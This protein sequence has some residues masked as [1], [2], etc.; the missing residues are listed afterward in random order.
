MRNL[1]YN[2]NLKERARILRKNSTRAEIRLW[3]ELLRKKQMLGYRFLRQRPIDMYIVDFFNKDLK[4]IIEVDGKSHD[5]KSNSDIERDC[6]LGEMGYST[7]RFTNEEILYDSVTAEK[8]I[9]TRI[10]ELEKS[11][12]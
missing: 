8:K 6:K 1:D 3:C 5:S 12:L 2:K 7:L 4:L 9:K 10:S 11:P